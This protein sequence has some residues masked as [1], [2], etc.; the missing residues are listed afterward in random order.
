MCGDHARQ[1][2]PTRNVLA[3]EIDYRVKATLTTSPEQ[4]PETR[5]RQRDQDAQRS[6]NVGIVGGNHPTTPGRKLASA[7]RRRDARDARRAVLGRVRVRPELISA[8]LASQA[9]QNLSPVEKVAHDAIALRPVVPLRNVVTTQ[10][11]VVARLETTRC[12]QAHTS[13]LGSLVLRFTVPRSK[14]Q[15]G[16]ERPIESNRLKN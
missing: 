4:S 2:G 6:Q 5:H 14:T 3:N 1:P 10:G 8:Y 12:A 9:R 16:H 15:A 7:E 13:P 11:G